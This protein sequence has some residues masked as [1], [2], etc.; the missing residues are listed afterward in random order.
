MLA[1]KNEVIFPIIW[2]KGFHVQIRTFNRESFNK[3]LVIVVEGLIV[4]KVE[5]VKEFIY[6]DKYCPIQGIGFIGIVVVPQLDKEVVVLVQKAM[7]KVGAKHA[8]VILSIGNNVRAS[9]YWDN[10]GVNLLCPIIRKDILII[11]KIY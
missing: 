10:G 8:V 9:T 3:F 11:F 1:Q 7:G 4:K 5:I 2:V 6:L